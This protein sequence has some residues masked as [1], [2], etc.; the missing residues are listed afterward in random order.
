M[1][2]FALVIPILCVVLFGIIQFGILY[3]DYVTLTDATRVGARKAAVSRHEADPVG[4]DRGQGRE[5][6]QRSRRRRKLTSSSRHA[7]VGARRRRDRRCDVSVRESTCWG[8]SW[9]PGISN[10]RPRSVWN[11]RASATIVA[12]PRSSPSSFSSPLLGAVAHRARRRLVVPR[13]AR[14]AVGRRRRRARGR[15]GAAGQHRPGK[16]SSR[17]ST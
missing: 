13:A 4:G 2:E 7:A 16:P 17:R 14:H 5:L 15:A 3:K 1:V 10:P 11:E 9:R 6:G 8:S 12:R